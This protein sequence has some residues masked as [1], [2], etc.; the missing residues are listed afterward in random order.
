M[1]QM[2][3]LFNERQ[4][5]NLP[6]TFEVTPRK[7]GKEHCKAIIMRSGKMVETTIHAH[8]DKGNS[9][10]EDDNDAENYMQDEKNNAATMDNT[11]KS[12]K[13]LVKNTPMKVKESAI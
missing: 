9:V 6:N 10:E 2:A 13:T 8:E 7:E 12:L 5:G 3:S 11:E 1:G 4:Q